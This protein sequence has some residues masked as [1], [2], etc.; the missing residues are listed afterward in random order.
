MQVD[1]VSGKGKDT[2]DDFAG[3][4]DDSARLS[5]PT[6]HRVPNR[7]QNQ[8]CSATQEISRSHRLPDLPCGPGLSESRDDAFQHT[9]GPCVSLNAR[10][11]PEV[12]LVT[13][14]YSP[15]LNVLDS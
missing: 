7:P 1:A 13:G 9:A 4:I 8:R 3:C 5:P 12:G 11:N 2:R 10:P 14:F 6:A 15:W